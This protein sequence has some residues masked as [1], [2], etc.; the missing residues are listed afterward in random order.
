[1]GAYDD[2]LHLPRPQS[3]RPPMPVADRAAQFA[4]FAALVGHKDVVAEAARL[5]EE[6]R[7]LADDEKA[8]LDR[9]MGRL[10]DSLAEGPAVR[11]EYFI[12]DPLKAGGA[13]ACCEGLVR[14]IDDIGGLLI[15]QEGAAVPLAAIDGLEF[16]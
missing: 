12:E 14:A 2:I 7:V 11:V 5:T 6:R 10:R 4:P 9:R 15:F 3:K 16:L 13:Y 1:M 8:Q